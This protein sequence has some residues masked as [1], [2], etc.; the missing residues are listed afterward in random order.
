MTHNLTEE[1]HLWDLPALNV[2]SQKVMSKHLKYLVNLI[3]N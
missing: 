1:L 2:E 3:N